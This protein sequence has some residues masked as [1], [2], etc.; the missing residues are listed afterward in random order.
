MSFDRDFDEVFGDPD[1]FN[2]KFMKRFQSELHRIIEDMK[3]GKIKGT[4][5]IRQIDEPGVKGYMIRGQFGL[6][7]PL[8][9]LEP[10]E[11]F[12]R[13]PLPERPLR[14]SRDALKA[15]REPLAD[16]FEEEN[17][18][19]IYVELPGED[20]SDVK[21]NIKGHTAEIETRNFYKKIDLPDLEIAADAATSHYKNGVLEITIPRKKKLR[22]KD[23][24]KA[25]M[26]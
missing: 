6:D 26:V 2:S 13:R 20:K 9:P 25:R 12:R 19:K 21:L 16:V 17:A 3:A 14:V 1:I 4:W 23:M 15:P 11:P 10:L 8:E 24:R 22:D 18:I 7:E 5:Q